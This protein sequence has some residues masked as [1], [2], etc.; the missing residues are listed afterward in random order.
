MFLEPDFNLE[1]IYDID[2]S[3]LKSVGI[4]LIL[5]DLDSTLMKSKSGKFSFKTLKIKI[6][7][8][9]HYLKRIFQ[10]IPEQRSLIQ[11]FC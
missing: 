4:K 10:F 2:I 5:F 1:S 3:E 8:I 9:R 7:L 11:R 6:I